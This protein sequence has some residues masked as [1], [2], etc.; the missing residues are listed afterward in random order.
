MYWGKSGAPVTQTDGVFVFGGYDKTKIQGTGVTF[1][2]K[3]YTT[4]CNSGMLLTITDISLTF[5]NETGIS[6]FATNSESLQ[7]CILPDFPVLMTLPGDPNDNNK[8]YYQ[9]LLSLIG[10][11]DDSNKHSVGLN[12]WGEVFPTSD[13]LVHPIARR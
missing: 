13:K 10:I 9:L 7:A 6:L 4:L 12:F 11:P 5:P 1:P 2:L 8:D 3:N